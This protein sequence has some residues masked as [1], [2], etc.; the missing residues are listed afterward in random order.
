[1]GTYA[2][3]HTR[4]TNPARA[5][6]AEF[7]QV[8]TVPGAEVAVDPG[9]V[10]VQGGLAPIGATERL[11]RQ[12][13]LARFCGVVALLRAAVSHFRALVPLEGAS[14]ERFHVG[15]SSDYG[16]LVHQGGIVPLVGG[17][18]SYGEYVLAVRD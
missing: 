4:S 12:S 14:D 2:R 6:S 7:R 3:C 11:R 9:L 17:S 1:M 13:G 15:L 16:R 18:F 10:S 5:G 8:G